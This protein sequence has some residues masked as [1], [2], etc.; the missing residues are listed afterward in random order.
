MLRLGTFLWDLSLGTFRLN[1]ARSFA[2]SLALNRSLGIFH[3]EPFGIVRLE[4]SGRLRQPAG[5]PSVFCRLESF[6]E[7]LL[8]AISGYLSPGNA[9]PA[10]ASQLGLSLGIFR[11]ELPLKIVTFESFDWKLSFGNFRFEIFVLGLAPRNFH[12]ETL[13][14]KLSFWGI[15]AWKFSP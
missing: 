6:D 1:I 9:R 5:S 13:A 12:L 11:W 14:L 4:T 15:F 10:C 3:L 2:C 7:D 8:L